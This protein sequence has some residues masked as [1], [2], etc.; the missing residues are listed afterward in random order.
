MFTA[1]VTVG[2]LVSATGE[3]SSKKQAEMAAALDAWNRL[4]RHKRKAGAPD[5]GA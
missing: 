2:T 4:V 3:G 1:T 5:R